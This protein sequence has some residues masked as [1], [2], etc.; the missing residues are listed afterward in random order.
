MFRLL[1]VLVAVGIAIYKT[2]YVHDKA[3]EVTPSQ[4]TEKPIGDFITAI[5]AM[6]FPLSSK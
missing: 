2:L 6:Q 1:V 4:R 5:V 3:L